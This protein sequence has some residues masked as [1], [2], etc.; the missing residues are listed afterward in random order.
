MPCKNLVYRIV[1]SSQRTFDSGSGV[2]ERDA[3]VALFLPSKIK[4]HL[5]DLV[6]SA[7]LNEPCVELELAT[8]TLYAFSLSFKVRLA[9]RLEI[10]QFHR[11]ATP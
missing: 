11:V 2:F 6:A 7:L 4:V 8:V 10:N 5:G 3:W 1:E 9:F